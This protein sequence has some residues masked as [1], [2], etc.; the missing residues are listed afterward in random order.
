[1]AYQ[2]GIKPA[3]FWELTPRQFF[4]CLEGHKQQEKSDMHK[5]A[6][7]VAWQLNI[8]SKETITP[9]RLL[10]EE[11]Q[12]PTFATAREFREYADAK[13]AEYEA[14]QAARVADRK[15]KRHG[16]RRHQSQH[17]R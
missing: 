9:G 2:I 13:Q 7:E 6:W 3:E 11:V 4:A 17:Q 14:K 1:M 8:W 5:R 12:H 15:A 16:N 10:G